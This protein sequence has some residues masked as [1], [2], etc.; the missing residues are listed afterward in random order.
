MLNKKM[1][2]LSVFG[3]QKAIENICGSD[4]KN[5]TVLRDGCLLIQTKNKKQA[6]RLL[7]NKTFAGLTT[8]EV[9]EHGSLNTCKGFVICDAFKNLTTDEI[10][11]GLKEY[12]VIKAEKQKFRKDD[13]WVEST[14][15][16]LTFKANNFPQQIKIGYLVAKVRQYIPNPMRCSKCF[17]YGHTKK[18]CKSDTIT[19]KDCGEENIDKHICKEVKC[20]NCKEAH[21]ATSKECPKYK[22]EYQIQKIRTVDR[23]SYGEARRKLKLNNK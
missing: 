1:S 23:I 18:H 4:V 3:V 13:E 16:I 21:T 14:T 12:K 20:I 7:K 6:D 5:T 2:D 8:V 19:C 11:E 17:K 9:T 22:E 15:A 10:V